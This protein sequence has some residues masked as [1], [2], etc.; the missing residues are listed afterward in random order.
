VLKET[1]PGET[2][3]NAGKFTVTLFEQVT[4]LSTTALKMTAPEIILPEDCL[5]RE[6]PY[7]SLNQADEREENDDEDEDH[8][9][10]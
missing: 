4:K 2:G 10:F 1:C 3:E 9:F 5:T 8:F 6:G 7:P